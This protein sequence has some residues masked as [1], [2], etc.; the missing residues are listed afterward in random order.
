MNAVQSS[1]ITVTGPS[2]TRDTWHLGP[3][4]PVATRAPCAAKL[5]DDGL[6][7][8][9]RDRPGGGRVHPGR[10][11]LPGVAVERELRHDQHLRPHLS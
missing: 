9:L 11:S 10:L 6:D 5:V 8:G 4:R 3:E 2:F 1:T 7:Q